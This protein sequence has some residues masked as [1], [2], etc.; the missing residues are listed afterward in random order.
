MLVDRVRR[1]GSLLRRLYSTR[2]R[3]GGRTCKKR[4]IIEGG[5][6]GGKRPVR[7]KAKRGA[8]TGEKRARPGA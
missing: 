8:P 1:C 5:R 6:S 3:D 2:R 7:R 4:P